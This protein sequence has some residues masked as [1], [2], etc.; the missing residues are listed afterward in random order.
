MPLCVLNTSVNA[1]NKLEIISSYSIEELNSRFQEGVF[2]YCVMLWF[3][4]MFGNLE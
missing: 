4:G 1:I 3:I 2:L